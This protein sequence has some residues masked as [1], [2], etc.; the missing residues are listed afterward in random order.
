[1]APGARPLGTG[2]AFRAIA[3]F[4]TKARPARVRRGLEGDRTISP[5]R[6]VPARLVWAQ[7]RPRRVRWP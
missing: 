7:R 5:R 6:L 2:A 3:P 1:M 4:A